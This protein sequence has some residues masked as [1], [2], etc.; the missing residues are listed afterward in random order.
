MCSGILHNTNLLPVVRYLPLASLQWSAKEFSRSP[1][2][3]IVP[4]C[5]LS[6]PRKVSWQVVSSL[7]SAHQ[8]IWLHHVKTGLFSHAKAGEWFWWWL[9]VS[10]VSL[11]CC[12][13]DGRREILYMT[14]V[15]QWA[16]NQD[17]N[18]NKIVKC[19]S[20]VDKNLCMN[21]MKDKHSP[22]TK[23]ITLILRNHSKWNG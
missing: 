10:L 21:Q 13:G 6:L 22:I 19:F 16:V 3:F 20:S 7:Q 4:K 2:T 8:T 15:L 5:T 14:Q 9:V 11:F 17:K 1:N 18:Q 23:A 12:G